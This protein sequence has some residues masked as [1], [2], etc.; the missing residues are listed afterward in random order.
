MLEQTYK[1]TTT[2]PNTSAIS[3]DIKDHSSLERLVSNHDLID[4]F[5]CLHA[6]CV[7][8]CVCVCVFVRERNLCLVVIF[9]VGCGC[10][11]FVPY[12]LHPLVAQ[13][14]ITHKVNM[15]TS[16][17]VSPQLQVSAGKGGQV[18]RKGMKVVM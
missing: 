15:L 6:V 13:Q 1:L 18:G 16:S 11:S 7:R 9:F 5:A 14:C 10:G 3:L 8:V 4:R 17:Y 2:Y 12:Q